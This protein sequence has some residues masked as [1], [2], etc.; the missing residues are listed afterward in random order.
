MPYHGRAHCVQATHPWTRWLQVRWRLAIF[1]NFCV[2]SRDSKAQMCQMRQVPSPTNSVWVCNCRAHAVHTQC[3]NSPTVR[4]AAAPKAV[5]I[6]TFFKG[7]RRGKPGN[8]ALQGGEPELGK[9]DDDAGP[10]GALCVTGLV[11]VTEPTVQPRPTP[12]WKH[13]SLTLLPR[14]CVIAVLSFCLLRSASVHALVP[15][16]SQKTPSA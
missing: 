9:A 10:T 13:S 12:G 7:R 14:Y 4:H 6:S 16:P 2:R 15:Y 5:R 8:M 11:I 3:R 1:G